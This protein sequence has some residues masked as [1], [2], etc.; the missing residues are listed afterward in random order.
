[1]TR[2]LRVDRDVYQPGEYDS[3]QRLFFT[4]LDDVRGVFV[5]SRMEARN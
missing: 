4:A 5:V 2:T 1:V 3:L